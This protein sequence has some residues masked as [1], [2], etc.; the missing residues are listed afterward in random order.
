MYIQTKNFLRRLKTLQPCIFLIGCAALFALIVSS[1]ASGKT[2]SSE[3]DGSV[4]DDSTTTEDPELSAYPDPVQFGAAPL[5]RD[6]VREVTLA[7]TG[8]SD[9]LISHIR[10]MEL[11]QVVEYS[12]TP[13]GEMEVW[14]APTESTVVEVTLHPIDGQ[15]DIASLEIVSNMPKDSITAVTLES[16]HDGSPIL[17]SCVLDDESTDPEPFVDCTLD[18][19]ENKPLLDYGVLAFGN[20]YTRVVTLRNGGEG[21]VPLELTGAMVTS[22]SSALESRFSVELYR[23]DEQNQRQS[24]TLPIWLAAEDPVEGYPADMILVDVIFTADIDGTIADTRLVLQTNDPDGRNIP[25]SG[26]V[27]GCPENYWDINGDPADGCEYYCVYQGPEVCNTGQDENCN[28][29]QNEGNALGCTDYYRDLD[30]DDYGVTAD[31]SCLCEPDIPNHYTATEDGDCNDDD[32]TIHPDAAE[33]C[34]ATDNNCNGSIDENLFQPCTISNTY[35]SCEGTE[36]C[37]DGFWVNCDAATPAAE[38]CGNNIDDDCNGATDE[39]GA[40]GCTTY[41]RDHDNDTW[42]ADDDARC[43]CSPTGEY[44]AD[45][46]GDCD[47]NDASANPDQ[48][49]ICNGQDDNCDGTTDENGATGCD[50]YYRDHDDDTW[51]MDSDTL[52]MCGPQGEYTATRGQDCEDNASSINPGASETCNSVDD[53]CDG[54]TDFADDIYEP[55]NSSSQYA[56]RGSVSDCDG[57]I[58]NWSARLSKDNDV[59]WFRFHDEDNAGCDIYPE[60][61]FTSNPGNYMMCVYVDC[62]EY[63]NDIVSCENG[64]HTS[65]GPGNAPEGCCSTSFVRI[66]HSCDAPWYDPDDSANLYIKVS[67]S[68]SHNCD[69]YSLEAGDD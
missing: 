64:F 15:V 18:P 60:V 17:E 44:D 69:S 61:Q 51:G 27:S 22:D 30:H 58:L 39:Q 35:G 45:R 67:S 10:I 13:N 42:G 25:I 54:T 8:G 38:T 46:D 62:T 68:G 53:D 49:E 5:Y 66:N 37:Q 11:D 3:D 36:E 55:N 1:C 4:D 6:T 59:D 16:T 63:G 20:D 65:T 47:D 50:V 52:C 7:N 9:L 43:L 34:D 12:V 21:N 14:L 56:N 33:T 26:V 29:M 24:V 32:T 41:Y 23:Y 57:H 31:A 48:T 40:A 19:I 2:G 28:G